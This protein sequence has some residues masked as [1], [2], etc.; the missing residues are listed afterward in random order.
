MIVL[1]G[2]T[3]SIG[4]KVL[5]VAKKNGIEVEALCANNNIELLN[6]QIKEFRPR[7]VAIGNREKKGLVKHDKVFCGSEGIE[8]MLTLSKSKKVIN[9]LVGFS[10]LMPTYRALKLGKKVALANKESLVAA[11]AFLDIKQ[12]SAIDSEHFALSYLIQDRPIKNMYITA[13]GGAFRDKKLSQLKEVTL[14]DALKHPNWSMG[15]KITVDSATMMNK[16]FEILEAKWLFSTENIDAFI[17][18]TST[19]HA[20]IEFVDGSITAHLSSPD[21]TLPITYALLDKVEYRTIKPINPL[22]LQNI[23]FSK[24]DKRQYPLW[25]IKGEILKN[26]LRGTVLNSANDVATELFLNHKIGYLEISKIVLECFKKFENTL[27]GSIEDIFLID[28]EVKEYIYGSK[29]KTSN[30]YY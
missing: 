15:K 16:L 22:K 27:P 19:V 30:R 18:K 13:S 2:S 4:K 26:P 24:I 20:M 6:K 17:E 21:M 28:K 10:G 29:Y 23:S 14:E 12:I 1:L 7:F 8:E 9:A 5:S 25:E 3:G 11:G